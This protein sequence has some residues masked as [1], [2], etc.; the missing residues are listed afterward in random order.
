MTG[1]PQGALIGRLDELI[2]ASTRDTVEPR[3]AAEFGD[4]AAALE[5]MF[6]L[7]VGEFNPGRAG[8]GAATFQF[9]ITGRTDT[10]HFAVRIQAGRCWYE[11]GTVPA[12]DVCIAID[13]P[14]MLK[15]G[16]GRLPGAR[17]YADGQRRITSGSA[18]TA[19]LLGEWFDHPEPVT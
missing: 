15:M 5:T 18:M 7:L 17:A 19:A 11:R 2:A 6:E 10:Y 16:I 3:I 13:M 4:P 1:T 8:G 9:D 14:E 12:P